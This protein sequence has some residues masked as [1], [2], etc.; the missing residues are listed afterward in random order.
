M[1]GAVQVQDRVHLCSAMAGMARSG[2]MLLC[3]FFSKTIVAGALIK[4]KPAPN[5]RHPR[6]P[7]TRVCLLLSGK[8]G[9]ALLRAL[10][11]EIRGLA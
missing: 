11:R 5:P 9:V 1:R 8:H 10:D 3:Y 6:P 4:R 2:C 7:R